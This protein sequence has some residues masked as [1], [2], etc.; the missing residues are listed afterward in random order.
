MYMGDI[1]SFKNTVSRKPYMEFQNETHQ[2]CLVGPPNAHPLL[3]GSLPRST[4][5]AGTRHALR[6]QQRP[7][8]RSQETE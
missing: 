3:V 8:D 1:I 6:S 2:P 5:A 4:S 7:F